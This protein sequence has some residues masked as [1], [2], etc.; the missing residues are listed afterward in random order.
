MDAK[1]L[2]ELKPELDLFLERYF[3]MFGREENYPHARSLMHGLL[4]GGDRRNVENIAETIDGGVVRTLQ[5]FIAQNAWDDRAILTEVRQH[6]VESL[7]DDDAVM[8]VDE[9]GFPKKGTKS[10]GVARQYAGIL[11]RV[12][13]CQIGVFVDYCSTHGHVLCDRRLFLPEAWTNDRKRCAEAGIPEGVIFRTKP[14]LAAEMIQ[15]A[16]LERTPF[17]WVAG[18]SVYGNSPVFVQTV[19]VLEKWYVLDVSS[20]TWVWTNEPERRPLKKGAKAAGRPR[21]HG[22][23]LTKPQQVAA[24]AAGLPAS[25]WKR[26]TVAE[27]SQGPRVYEYAELTVWFSEE[28]L[29]T[30]HP[31][32]LLIRRSLGQDT[33][34]KYQRSNAPATIPLRKLAEVAGC[35]WCVEMD[36]QCGKGECGLD[37]YET[38]GW[39][40]WHHHTA[41]SLMALWFL[42]LQKLRLGKKTPATHGAGGSQR[43]AMPPR[44]STLGRKRNPPLVSTSPKTQRARQSVPHRA[45][46]TG[47]T[48]AAK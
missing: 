22:V 31:E 45:A 47:K 1:S 33:E 30:D 13:N 24:L 35:R 16:V 29:P 48:I 3:P 37:E 39:V 34:L 17:R 14:E 11:G 20:E 44:S 28:R 32:R 40:G 21:K 23:A 41:L 42:T 12:D 5:K 8:I 18:D 26:V 7:G 36:F 2:R 6:V 15:N 10:A 27:G 46:Q 4:A 9:T 19:R 38:R 25:A 43:A